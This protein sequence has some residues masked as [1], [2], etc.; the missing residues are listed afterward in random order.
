MKKMLF[1]LILT[2]AATCG[3]A[4]GNNETREATAPAEASSVLFVGVK[5]Y[6][7]SSN[8]YTKDQLAEYLSVAESEVE[9]RFNDLFR[10]AFGEAA[11][12]RNLRIDACGEASSSILSNI[13]YESEDGVTH[14]ALTLTD[15]AAR[16][17]ENAGARYVL[18]CDQY[19]IQKVEFPYENFAHIV[20]YSLFDTAGAKVYDG[21]YQYAALDLGDTEMLARQLRRAADRFVRE[22]L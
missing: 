17:I 20:H 21:Q 22:V 8:Y 16:A 1:T 4:E 11:G 19:R 2:T 7:V 10:E 12:R 18:V 3:W 9:T 15:E 5:E 14:S 13:A 6:N